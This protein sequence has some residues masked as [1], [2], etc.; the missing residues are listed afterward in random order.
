MMILIN[1]DKH[2]VKATKRFRI[3]IKRGAYGVGR[4]VDIVL[5]R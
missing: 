5:I 4:W 1:D 2:F 3:I